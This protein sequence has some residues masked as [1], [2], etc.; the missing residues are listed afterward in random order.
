M[1]SGFAEAQT[2]KE[3]RI[4]DI[5]GYV[6]LK[7][8]FHMHTV[9]SD[10]I[11]WPTI[12]VEEA[13]REGLDA[14]SITDHVEYHPHEDDVITNHNRPF[15]LAEPEAAKYGLM[16]I[17]GA[18]IT[19]DQPFGHFNAIFLNDIDPLDVEDEMES[20][21]NAAAQGAFLFWN[22]PGDQW[23]P[24]QT[25]ILEKGW[26]HGIEVVNGNT[27]YPEVHR[28][29]LEKGLTLVCNSD[30]HN[31]LDYDYDPSK[32]EN[33]PITLVF[34]EDANP[35]A[36]KEALIKGRTAAY[37]KDTLIGDEKFLR[38]IFE[39]SVRV[40][41]PSEFLAKDGSATI[42]VYNA[43][44]IDFILER[45][46][47][48]EEYSVPEKILLPADRT[49][50]VK[51]RKKAGSRF[52]ENLF[53]VPFEVANL[54]IAPEQ[55]LPAHL[56]FKAFSAEGIGVVPADSAQP[57]L[58]RLDCGDGEPDLDL[59]YTRDGRAPTLSST[60]FEVPFEGEEE[61]T[62][63]VCAFKD[64]KPFGNV[65][66]RE[67]APH[68]ALGAAINL[69][70]P[71][72]EKYT[73][74]GDG[75]LIDGFRATENYRDGQWQGFEGVDLEAYLDLGRGM[76]V[77]KIKATFLQDIPV[78]IFPPL[79]VK[80]FLSPDGDD[81]QEVARIQFDVPDRNG[82]RKILPVSVQVPKEVA[83]LGARYIKVRAKNIGACPDW[84]P[85]SGGKAW[86][87]VDEIMVE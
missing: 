9:F 80:F 47:D 16:L 30:V 14:I 33:R 18:E 69:K 71:Y 54:W 17:K 38:L 67:V 39:A 21:G 84:H 10:G 8:D 60:P 76:H 51:I 70:S 81:F 3:I 43:S 82:K 74:G 26:M 58:F 41:N 6:T 66:T 44:E 2:R 53:R 65:Y 72:S 78:W 23:Y 34:A 15:E 64:G 83:A 57:R 85:G 4:P 36:L 11:V 52:G 29:A 5:P 61:F 75:A 48:G 68:K 87:F 19:R 37:F 77:Q 49:V 62:L 31:R 56:E 1:L 20:L 24:I 22:H 7:C 45:S 42:Q 12:R 73:G 59:Y 55:G 79:E 46:A 28:R 35:I 63:K 40:R 13:W 27:Y 50:R 25:E 32:G 86:L